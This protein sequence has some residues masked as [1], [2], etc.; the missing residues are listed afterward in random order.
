[1][2]RIFARWGCAVRYVVAS[3]IDRARRNHR[4][5]T[6]VAPPQGT[7]TARPGARPG[8]L[9]G[10]LLVGRNRSQIG[11][12]PRGVLVGGYAALLSA[13]GRRR[14]PAQP[15]DA[16]RRRPVP[17][18]Q[19][20]LRGNGRI[21]D[22]MEP[23]GVRDRVHGRRDLRDPH[24]LL[25]Y[26]GSGVCMGAAQRAGDSRHHRCRDAGDHAGG[27]PRPRNRQVAAQRR[28]RDDPHGVR[29]PLRASGLGV[30]ARI[31][32]AFRSVPVAASAPQPVQPRRFR[33]DDRRRSFGLRIR[34]DP[35]G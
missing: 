19:S 11:A 29:H 18:G 25:L 5:N 7:W 10:G 33:P 27:D 2:R 30:V 8:A 23:L 35:G 34:R 31:D 17:V 16:P 1:M 32:F 24:G 6:G 15:D 28:H 14:D 21:S 13:A 12:R 4:P 20:R 9:R 3:L 22:R 26:G